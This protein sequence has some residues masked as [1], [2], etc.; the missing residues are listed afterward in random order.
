MYYNRNVSQSTPI[1]ISISLFEF[2]GKES[3]DAQALESMI[4]QGY[5]ITVF[6]K[7]AYVVTGKL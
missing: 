3:A 7:P 4:S 2:K 6:P 5:K 1:T